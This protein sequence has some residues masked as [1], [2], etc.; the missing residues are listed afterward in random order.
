MNKTFA[1]EFEF[2]DWDLMPEM[3]SAWKLRLSQNT[4]NRNSIAPDVS[5]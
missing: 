4:N 1:F 3:K 5:K 2:I